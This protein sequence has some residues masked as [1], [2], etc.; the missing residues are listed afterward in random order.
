M[1][2]PLSVILVVCDVLRID[3]VDRHRIR[4]RRDE[5]VL[6]CV[7]LR[8]G[9]APG[10]LYIVYSSIQFISCRCRR[11]LQV[12]RYLACCTVRCRQ[13]LCQVFIFCADREALIC[14]GLDRFSLTLAVFIQLEGRPGQRGPFF[15]QLVDSDTVVYCFFAR[16]LRIRDIDLALVVDRHR[17][18]CPSYLGCVFDN[19]VDSRSECYC[20]DCFGFYISCRSFCFFQIQCY[21][22]RICRIRFFFRSFN[23]RQL[24]LYG[25][26][27]CADGNRTIRSSEFFYQN[28]CPFIFKYAKLGTRQM[29]GR[30]S[31]VHLIY[32]YAVM[33]SILIFVNSIQECN[34]CFDG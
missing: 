22:S 23:H 19:F 6:S 1:Y 21:R 5:L 20:M 17:I 29:I 3:S 7:K 9:C 24:T 13:L 16:L 27:A 10:N 33:S 32:G 34:V 30:V 18:Y 12:Q 31:F 14:I 11:L 8:L 2:C 25:G 15:V 28:C 26:V 4:C